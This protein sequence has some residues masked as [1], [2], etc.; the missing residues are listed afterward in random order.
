[1]SPKRL[2]NNEIQL[3]IVPRHVRWPSPEIAKSISWDNLRGAVSALH[4][5]AEVVEAQCTQA[6][7]NTDLSSGGI[8]RRREAVGRQALSELADHWKPAESAEK[9]VLADIKLI[10]SKMTALPEPPSTNVDIAMQQEIRSHIR[11]LKSPI[12]FVM[13]SI[14]DP[15]TLAAVLTAPAYL[16]GLTETE[17]GVVKQ[18]ARAAFHPDLDQHQKWLASSLDDLKEGVAE[19]QR[20]IME[21]C[22][23]KP[24][25]PKLVP[26]ETMPKKPAEVF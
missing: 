21:R 3:R 1:M 22:D 6:E 23:L 13:K 10:E 8:T 12:D 11:G 19:T 17:H 15:R 16:S 5:L 20:L 18:R 7:K 26:V 14:S 4:G 25:Q 2:S 24:E 9:S